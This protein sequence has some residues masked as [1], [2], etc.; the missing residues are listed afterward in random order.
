MLSV[1]TSDVSGKNRTCTRL[2][3]FLS[4]C[5]FLSGFA[6]LMTVAP[7]RAF[8]T[9]PDRGGSAWPPANMTAPPGMPDPWTGALQDALLRR[10]AQRQ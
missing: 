7:P 9:C 4:L 6:F 5:R 8:R 2:L 1:I 10:H 3:F